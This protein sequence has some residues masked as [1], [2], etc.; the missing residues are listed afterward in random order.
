M[1]DAIPFDLDPKIILERARLSPGS[2]EAAELSELVERVAAVARPRAVYREC[3]VD[4]RGE[5]SLTIEGRLFRSRTLLKVL[6]GKER[7]FAYVAS[8]GPEPDLLAA[9]DEDPLRRWWLDLI[10]TVLLE[11]A[12]GRLSGLLEQRYALGPSSTIGPGTGEAGVWPLA[13]QKELFALLEGRPAEI[14]VELTASCLMVPN[15]TVSGLRFPSAVNYRS[16]Q[17]CRREICPS[18][19][20][21]F[22]PALW[23]SVHA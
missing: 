9:G 11:A 21:E 15:K 23:E 18:R 4:G 7:V 8:C 10:K 16:C 19:A 6:D 2:E 12:R 14:G 3:F 13:Q 20:A 22:D 17:L 1:L 5:D